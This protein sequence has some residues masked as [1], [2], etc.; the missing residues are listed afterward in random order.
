MIIKIKSREEIEK[1]LEK[2]IGY[3]CGTDVGQYKGSSL[4]MTRAMLEFC[5][6]ESEPKIVLGD[7][8]AVAFDWYWHKDWYE[9]VEPD[10]TEEDLMDIELMN[11]M[12]AY[13][14]EVENGN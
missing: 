14:M 1:T 11:E 9:V 3:N 2:G 12:L 13:F 4:T 7:G 6:M 5:G 8:R 10:F